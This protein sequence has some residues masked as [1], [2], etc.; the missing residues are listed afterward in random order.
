MNFQFAKAPFSDKTLAELY[1]IVCESIHL[2]EIKLEDVEIAAKS[3]AAPILWK[4][5]SKK[6]ENGIVEGL[7][8]ARIKHLRILVD[9]KENNR[10]EVSEAERQDLA[11]LELS[12]I[13]HDIFLTIVM[14]RTV[15]LTKYNINKIEAIIKCRMQILCKWKMMHTLRRPLESSEG[16]DRTADATETTLVQSQQN[17]RKRKEIDAT[18]QEFWEKEFLAHQTWRNLWITL[19]GFLEY[20]RCIL[21]IEQEM[22]QTERRVWLV[23][24]LHS[25]TTHLEG[26]F[27]VQ[28]SRNAIMPRSIPMVWRKG[29][30]I[31]RWHR[32]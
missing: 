18:P 32:L 28:K 13:V 22:I 11:T 15:I 14:N 10:V 31:Q 26:V 6:G 24:V 27:L 3:E 9:K 19:R 7:F 12:A 21:R 20:A 5:R 23:P 4:Q 1:K 30:L 29:Q 16:T 2:S 17:K 25:N 8:V